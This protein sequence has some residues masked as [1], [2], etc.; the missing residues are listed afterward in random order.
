M[1]SKNSFISLL[2]ENSKRRL[3]A[4]ALSILGFIFAFPVYAALM[5]G[6]WNERLIDKSTT[7]KDIIFSYGERVVGPGSFPLFIIVVGLALINGLQSMAHLMNR[8]ELDLYNSIPVKR[9]KLFSVS[10]LN[11]VLI[12]VLPYF[13]F[14]IIALIIGGANGY[15][16]GASVGVAFASFISA[17]VLYMLIYTIVILA[18]ILTGNIIVAIMGSAVML[19]WPAFFVYLLNTLQMTFFKTWFDPN[20]NSSF[21]SVGPLYWTPEPHWYFSPVTLLMRIISEADSLSVL[22]VP[23]DLI[24]IVII[25]AVITA[26]LI[27]LCVL[28]YNKRPSEAAG[29]AIAFKVTEPVIDIIVTVP[30]AVFCGMIFYGSIGNGNYPWM[31]FGLIAG[32]LLTHAV[33]EIVYEFDFKACIHRPVCIAISAVLTV[34]IMCFFI[35]DLSGYDRYLPDASDVANAAITSSSLQS[36]VTVYGKDNSV[37][38]NDTF[39]LDSMKLKDIDDVNEIA[40][41]GIKICAAEKKDPDATEPVTCFIVSI[42]WKLNSGRSV[43]RTYTVN[44]ADSSVFKAYSSIYATKEYKDTVYPILTADRSA[45][46]NLYYTS[47]AG[48]KK[49]SL[50][51]TA[52]DKL[53][54]TYRVELYMQSA[55]DLKKEV[56]IG[57]ITSRINIPVT[58]DDP[59]SNGSSSYNDEYEW[60]IYPSFTKTIAL[61]KAAGTDVYSYADTSDIDYITIT[62]YTDADSKSKKYTSADQIKKILD[63]SVPSDYSYMDSAFYFADDSGYDIEITYK[64][65]ADDSADLPATATMVFKKGSVPGFV[66]TDIPIHV[67]G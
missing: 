54:E 63:S 66:K 64:P 31:I 28:L 11:G 61:L 10:Y 34:F 50:S 42:R 30:A 60:Y 19:S 45:I 25:S 49:L 44:S 57:L 9:N 39:R 5:I 15:V 21:V 58:S 56:P 37:M 14:L 20:I 67:Y 22:S 46:K 53:L 32:L 27:A 1:T 55:D 29:S 41:N 2:Y 23:D 12:F 47:P 8:R 18:C 40:E 24:Y 59:Y 7:V 3:W 38:D 33:I 4:I 52:V 48:E 51:K 43:Y 6:T 13:F 16:T 17:V 65:D 35:F 62:Y 36:S 26:V